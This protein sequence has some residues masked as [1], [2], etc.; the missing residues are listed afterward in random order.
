MQKMIALTPEELLRLLAEAKRDSARSHLMILLACKHGLRASEVVNLKLADVN[1]RESTI[2][3]ARLKNSLTTTQVL[4]THPGSPLLDEPRALRAY[5]RERSAADDGSGILFVS[6]HGGALDRSSFFRLFRRLAQAA[7]LPA[8]KQHPHVCKH[9]LGAL[10]ARQ[11]A[12][13]FC[14]RQALGHRSI[15]SSLVYAQVSDAD[16]SAVTKQVFMQAF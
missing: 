8:E 5:L 10:L 16:A 9:F 13:A 6:S 12:N 4:Q 1:L 2:H 7:G 14:I 11:G 3:C 15:S